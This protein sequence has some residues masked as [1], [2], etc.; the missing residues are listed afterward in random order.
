MTDI[1]LAFSRQGIAEV[2]ASLANAMS[3]AGSSA[4][5]VSTGTSPNIFVDITLTAKWHI[6]VGELLFQNN[7]DKITLEETD[8]IL[9]QLALEVHIDPPPVSIGG[10]WV[11]L[12]FGVSIKLPQI[13][14]FKSSDIFVT[15][16]AL[17]GLRGE[18][19]GSLDLNLFHFQTTN[20]NL[21]DT[22]VRAFRQRLV[23][24]PPDSSSPMG[25]F[26][27][28][29]LQD[30]WELRLLPIGLDVDLIDTADMA[31][32]AIG[33]IVDQFVNQMDRH[34]ANLP[35]ANEIRAF[36]D[37]VHGGLRDFVTGLLDLP[38]DAETW[39]WDVITNSE[40]VYKIIEKINEPLGFLYL[41]KVPDLPKFRVSEEIPAVAIKIEDARIKLETEELALELDIGVPA[42]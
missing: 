28:S 29:A 21:L 5:S 19:E 18:V 35:F 22:E 33:R 26:Y 38:D 30:G 13:T 3:G 16:V 37:D 34:I 2:L 14:V 17:E 1:T 24:S 40:I 39:L 4:L 7:P 31:G 11:D 15:A 32:D 8:L 6:E 41:V 10:G 9:D 36:I 42:F 27:R 25:D 23:D 12:P 20:L